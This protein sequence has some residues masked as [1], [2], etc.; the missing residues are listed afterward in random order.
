MFVKACYRKVQRK[1]LKINA[2]PLKHYEIWIRFSGVRVQC[3]CSVQ[4]F[5]PNSQSWW[6][7]KPISCT[8]QYWAGLEMHNMA[9]YE[10]DDK[11][12]G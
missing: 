12:S 10:N 5:F 3:A 2:K 8:V 7:S 9:Q 1:R 4:G 11:E 6:V